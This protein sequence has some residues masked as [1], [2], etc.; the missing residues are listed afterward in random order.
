MSK[1]KNFHLAA[2]EYAERGFKVLPLRERDKIPTL[3]KWQTYASDDLD[4]IEEWFGP[5][6]TNNHNIGVQLGPRSG[7]IDVEY[8]SVEGQKVAAKLF[9]EV[10]TPTYSSGNRSAHRLFL[11]Q[12]GLPQVAVIKTNDLELRLGGGNMGAQSVFPPSIHPSGSAYQWVPGLGLDEVDIQ[13]VPEALL[14]MLAN[15]PA[16]E[17]LDT[18]LLARRRSSEHWDRIIAGKSKVGERNN[19]ITSFIGLLLS[20]LSDRSIEDPK[21]LMTM[22]GVAIETA[23][24]FTEP[25]AEKEVEAAFRS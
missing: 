8:D 9:G 3:P 11:W 7:I 1:Q 2:L 10:Y 23:S 14:I 4:K 15:D 17:S 12:E 19:D 18:P 20:G 25:L 13:P 22:L 6:S 24:R 16:L 5:E 21:M